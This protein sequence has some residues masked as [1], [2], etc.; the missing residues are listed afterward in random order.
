MQ[1]YV[2][3]EKQ[4]ESASQIGVAGLVTGTVASIVSTMTLAALARAEGKSAVQPT[5]ATSHWLHGD[6]AAQHQHVD[7]EHTVVGYATHHGSAIFWAVPF[8]IW[9]AYDPPQSFGELVGKA[10][11]TSAVAAAVDYGITPRRLTPGWELTISKKSM[12]GAFAGLALG[13][14][15]G[16]LV[17]RALR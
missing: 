9:L 5:N 16:A 12:V 6:E 17:S 8:E 2:E 4:M 7:F 13:L 11:V 1:F 15:A 3:Q 10:A 14:A